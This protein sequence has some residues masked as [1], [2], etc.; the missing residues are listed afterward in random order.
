MGGMA[1]SSTALV[2]SNNQETESFPGKNGFNKE[3]EKK[4]S[5][6]KLPTKE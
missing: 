3:R 4:N 2:Q 6:L 1:K 5:I